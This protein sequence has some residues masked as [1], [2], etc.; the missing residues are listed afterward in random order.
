MK[1]CIIK[2]LYYNYICKFL[3]FGF[4]GLKHIIYY[5][6][7]LKLAN[8]NKFLNNIVIDEIKTAIEQTHDMFVIS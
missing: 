7:T 8:F 4:V 1:L 5:V 3:I 2:N 6:N